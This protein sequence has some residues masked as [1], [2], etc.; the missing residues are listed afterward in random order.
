[1]SSPVT[2]LEPHKRRMS[3][4]AATCPSTAGMPGARNWDALELLRWL[5]TGGGSTGEKLVAQFLLGVWDPVA[6]WADVARENDFSPEEA[7]QAGGFDFFEAM[8]AFDARQVQA[9]TAWMHNPFW[10]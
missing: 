9:L 7:L 2:S 3:E 1:M 8:H 4:L 6:H 10:P 5:C